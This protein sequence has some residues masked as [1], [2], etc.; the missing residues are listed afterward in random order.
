MEAGRTL[1]IDFVEVMTSDI[2]KKT[3]SGLARKERLL[4]R[5]LIKVDVAAA[6]RIYNI[7]ENK[8]ETPPSHWISRRFPE[9]WIQ[10]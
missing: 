7:V 1:V 8:A 9:I 5:R 10:S 3:F 6:R 2:F 4:L